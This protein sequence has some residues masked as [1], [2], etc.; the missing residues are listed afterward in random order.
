MKDFQ[1]ARKLQQLRKKYKL[2][3]Q[4]AELLALPLLLFILFVVLYSI[5]VRLAKEIARYDISSF[6]DASP[7][8]P[9]PVLTASYVP[10][11]SAQSAVVMDNDSKVF[12]YAKN[13][14]L[15]F[16]MA[17]T[18][19]L[20]T[21]LVALDQFSLGDILTVYDGSIEGS[22]A[23]L[24]KGEQYTLESLLYAMLLPSA[25]D[26]AFTIADNYPGGRGAFISAMNEKA[27][28]LHLSETQYDDPA[29]LTDDTNF[30]TAIDLAHLSSI[31]IADPVIARITRTKERTITDLAGS[32]ILPLE[33]LNKLLG[34][35]G[36]IGI[37][38]GYTEGAGGVLT[39][40]KKEGNHLLIIVVMRS[41]DRFADTEQLLRM[42]DGHVSYT[43]LVPAVGK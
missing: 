20:M 7:L 36:V 3:F 39:T 12:L 14:R 2:F 26:A 16:S 15:R 31:A 32:H 17:S 41:L 34:T 43:S 1:V 4:G 40:A 24:R 21:A 22:V 28:S 35:E 42:V 33:N 37:K 19:K 30:T 13:P 6:T 5:H 38:T 25:N 10:V 23:G 18:T 27:R 29:G 11:I 9:Y 8:T